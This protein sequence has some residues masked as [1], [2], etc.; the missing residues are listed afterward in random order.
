MIAG[1]EI[2]RLIEEFEQTSGQYDTEHRE[3]HEQT[4]ACET[5]FISDISGLVSTLHELG[6][7]S[8]DESKQLTSLQTTIILDKSVVETVS[9]V[10]AI[11]IEQYT[12][13]VT[14]RLMDNKVPLQAAIHCNKLTIFSTC[15]LA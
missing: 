15:P 9:K 14:E 10:R 3:H 8:A 7:L 12:D 11:G 1:P 13:F 2:S 6:N 5:K 4:S